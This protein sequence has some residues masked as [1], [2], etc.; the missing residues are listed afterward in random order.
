VTAQHPKNAEILIMV[1]EDEALIAAFEN[2]FIF[3]VS[4]EPID[5]SSLV[6][7]Y[8]TMIVSIAGQEG[9]LGRGL[10]RGNRRDEQWKADECAGGGD[11]HGG[12]LR[13]HSR[14]DAR[15]A[16]TGILQGKEDLRR[17]SSI[18]S[19]ESAPHEGRA[20]GQGTLL[21]GCCRR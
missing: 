21:R 19:H 13:R 8:T 11:G 12:G 10:V 4:D 2:G 3:L 14:H 9:K 18:G 5:S 1:E 7:Q 15:S 20:S 16:A 6:L 17:Q